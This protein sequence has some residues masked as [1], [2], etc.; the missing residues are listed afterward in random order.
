MAMTSALK[1]YYINISSSKKYPIVFGESAITC[2]DKNDLAG[3]TKG[4]IVTNQTI[5]NACAHLIDELKARLDLDLHTIVID[6]GEEYK[7]LETVQTIVNECLEFGVGRKDVLFSVGGGVVGDMAGF[8]A[9]I[10]LRGISFFQVPTSL[11]AQVD[12]AIGG[13]TGVNHTIGKNLIGTF[14]QPKKT[15]IDPRFLIT[16]PKEQM[17]EGLAEV[18]KYGVI[19]DKPLFWYLEEHTTALRTFTYENCPDV[20]QFVIDKSI[21]NKAHV[22]SKDER[23][24]EYREILNFGHTIG[25]AIESVFGY[26]AV[27]HGQ[28][29]ALGMVAESMLALTLKH[30]SRDG[31]DRIKQ[32]IDSFN[33]DFDLNE[34]DPTAFFKALTRDKKSA[35]ALFDM[36]FQQI[37]G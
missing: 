17:K 37:L 36:L 29:V 14:Y 9:S 5:L 24:S 35:K 28:A 23:E 2:I 19:M 26:Q 4:V 27:T 3:A 7:S 15:L 16:L 10:Y 31:C 33:Y 25:H 1:T 20:W 30:I 32:L 8:A 6:D 13:K 12:A 18:I 11:L 22:V 34:M 21:Q